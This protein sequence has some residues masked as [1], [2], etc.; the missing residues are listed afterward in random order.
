MQGASTE[1]IEMTQERCLKLQEQKTS[2]ELFYWVNDVSWFPLF[3]KSVLL[4]SAK[5]RPQAQSL[6]LPP[7]EHGP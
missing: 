2:K 6:W 3:P 1:W 4:L 7:I 5:M